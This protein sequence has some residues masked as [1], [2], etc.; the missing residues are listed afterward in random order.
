MEKGQGR[1]ANGAQDPATQAVRIWSDTLAVL[2]HDKSLTARDKGWFEGVIPEAVFGTTIVLTVA[3]AATQKALQT[4]LNQ[5]LL[6]IEAEHRNRHVLGIQNRASS[7]YAFRF[8]R[9]RGGADPYVGQ[10]A[11]TYG[12]RQHPLPAAE[13]AMPQQPVAW[14]TQQASRRSSPSS[15]RLIPRRYRR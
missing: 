3:N 13:Q 11:T 2:K 14:R 6:S 15:I 1:M 12:E 9:R 5:P 8:I 7:D 10:S 4:D